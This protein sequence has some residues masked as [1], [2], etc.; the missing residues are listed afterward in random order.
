MV[1]QST[2]KIIHHSSFSECVTAF[3]CS[4]FLSCNSCN[5]PTDRQTDRPTDLGI[6]APSWSLKIVSEETVGSEKKWS[7]KFLFQ[8]NI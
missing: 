6:K 8:K 7:E 3:P 2:I 5:G 1:T 4:L